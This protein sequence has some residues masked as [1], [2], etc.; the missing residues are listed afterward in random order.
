VYPGHAYSQLGLETARSAV[1]ARGIMG[2]LHVMWRSRS[3]GSLFVRPRFDGIFLANC[4]VASSHRG[5]GVFT[6]L[7]EFILDEVA[8]S[9]E[10]D[11]HAIELDVAWGNHDA[12][13]LYER[14]GFR[15]TAE[16]PYRGR[17]NLEGFRRM[18]RPRAWP[19]S[20]TRS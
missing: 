10:P 13:R 6:R 1:D 2:A 19:P 16:R 8:R 9:D 11:L 3:L 12:Q 7:F 5:Q 4:A 18:E 20:E 17:R 15:V 14:L